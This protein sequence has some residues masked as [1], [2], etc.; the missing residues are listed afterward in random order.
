M[1]PDGLAALA[2]ADSVGALDPNERAELATRR[3]SLSPEDQEELGRL[4]EVATALATAVDV[5]EPPA[6]VRQRVLDSARTSTRARGNLTTGDVAMRLGPGWVIRT[7]LYRPDHG[8]FRK[9]R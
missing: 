9:P 5:L 1:I 6:G 4:Y 7:K 3:A 8:L 2:L